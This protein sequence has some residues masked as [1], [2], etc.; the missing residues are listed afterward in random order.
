M[1][2]RSAIRSPSAKLMIGLLMA[3]AF[4]P[5]A[6]S[7]SRGVEFFEKKIRP[8]LVERCYKCHSARSEKVKGDLR[9]DSWEGML[10]GGESGKPGV[11]PGDDNKSLLIESIRYKNEDLQMPPPKEGKLSDEQIADFVSW[12]KMGAPYPGTEESEI[13]N[14]KSEIELWWSFQSIKNPTVPSVKNRAWVKSPVDNFILAKLEGNGLTPAPPTDKR[15]L[16]RRATFDLIGLP[17]TPREVE[18]FLSDNSP[19]AFAKVVDRLLASPHY[20]ERWGRHWLDVVRYTDSFDARGIG[21]EADVPEAYRYRDWVVNAF[22]HDLPYDQFIIQQIAGDILA[23]SGPEGFDADKLIATGVMAIG[24]WGTGDADKEKMLTDIVDDQIDVT[25]RAFLGLTLACARCHDHKFDPIPTED[26]YSLAGIYFSSH[27]LPRPGAKTAG[28]A[29]LRIPLASTTELDLRKEKEIRAAALEREI[30]AATRVALVNIPTRGA[31]N[32]SALTALNLSAGPDLPSAAANSGDTPLEFITIRLPARSVAVHPSPDR[33]AALAWQSPLNGAVEVRGRV[34][35]ADDKCGNGIEWVLYHGQKTLASGKIDNGG[36]ED[37][38][39]AEAEIPAGGL[40]PVAIFPKGKDHGCDTTVVELEIHERGGERR[41]WR[42]PDDVVGDLAAKANTGAWYFFAFQGEPPVTLAPKELPAEE[43]ASLA[44][45]K[46]ELAALRAE[47]SRP[48][49]VA[50]GLQEGG[51]PESAHAGI[52]DVQVHSRGRYYRLGRLVPRR[53]PRVLA[54]GNQQPITE[55]SGSLELAKWIASPAN[56]LTARVMVNR[57]WQHHF[58]EGLV[59]T[60]NN[61][62]KLG[63]RPTHPELLDYLA[64]RFIRAGWS[65]KSMQRAIMLSAV[66]QQSSVPTP[67]TLR[68]DPENRRLGRMNRRR[69][70]AEPLRDSL[71]AVAGELDGTLGAAAIRELD[72]R[73]R[74]LYLMTIRSDRSNYRMLF[75]AADPVSIVEKRIDSTVAPQ[76]LF[77][78]NHPFVQAQVKVLAQRLT[79]ESPTDDRGKIERLYQLLYGRP[80]T[81]QEMEVGL[82]AV[83]STSSDA[84][85]IADAWDQ[86]CQVLLCANEFIYVD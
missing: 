14:P 49:P 16:I 5:V 47:L 25:G 37:I 53:F 19:D 17:P 85:A 30:N 75:D 71:L 67:Q 34:A 44:R 31:Q 8:V 83:A 56:P 18:A 68:A 54:G 12:V 61:F 46:E 62:G 55:G 38:P 20:G 80:P 35:D 15:T 79:R 51:V 11:V 57:L 1:S 82:A 39:R 26:Y 40:I 23:T 76:A 63:E 73:R 66:Y 13:R 74:T 69:L 4:Y 60:P 36:Q 48:V 3:A 64:D 58:G 24:E 45:W 32:K 70:E 28:S 33:A 77:L 21:G 65:I 7:P 10:K 52:H 6:A 50:H 9:L 84:S 29:V 41:T 43:K 72:N 27:I 22:N 78:L 81:A 42:V 2:R 86:Y 59:R